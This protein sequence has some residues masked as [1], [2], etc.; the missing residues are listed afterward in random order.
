MAQSRPVKKWSLTA[1]GL[2]VSEIITFTET[3]KQPFPSIY[4]P[5]VHLTIVPLITAWP[6]YIYLFPDQGC[7]LALSLSTSP[8]L[9]SLLVRLDWTP[10]KTFSCLNLP[11]PAHNVRLISLTKIRLSQITFLT[12]V[13]LA[14]LKLVNNDSVTTVLP[15]RT[16]NHCDSRQSA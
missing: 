6:S 13:N 7:R 9:T 10:A 8:K 15:H 4:P 1:R 14:I 12:G 16:L 5:N 2:L 11:Q 3:V